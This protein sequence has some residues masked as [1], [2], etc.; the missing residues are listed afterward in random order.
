MK[1]EKN[2][3]FACAMGA[4]TATEHGWSTDPFR[5]SFTNKVAANVEFNNALHMT[6]SNASYF[7]LHHQDRLDQLG[8]PYDPIWLPR[9][10]KYCFGIFTNIYSYLEGEVIYQKYKYS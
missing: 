5:N 4:P 1:I 10:S 7:G 2:K 3:L 8:F 9:P 6:I